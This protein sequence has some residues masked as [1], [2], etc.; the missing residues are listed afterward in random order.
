MARFHININVC[1]TNIEKLQEKYVID[2]AI[3][4][5]APCHIICNHVTDYAG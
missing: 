5:L 2:M 3:N 1:D 4:A